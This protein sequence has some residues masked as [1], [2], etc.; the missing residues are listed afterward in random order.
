MEAPLLPD[1]SNQPTLTVEEAAEVFGVSRPLAYRQCNAY[2]RTNGAEGIPTIRLGRKL[3]CPT[4][5]VL[6]TLGV[7]S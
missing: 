6:R 4:A 2:L 1:P 7:E 3:L 5:A